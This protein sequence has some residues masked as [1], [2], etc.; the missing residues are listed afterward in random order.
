MVGTLLVL[1]VFLIKQASY[2][3]SRETKL[4]LLCMQLFSASQHTAATHWQTTA[5]IASLT[6][7][8]CSVYITVSHM[9]S[10]FLQTP[11]TFTMHRVSLCVACTTIPQQWWRLVWHL[12][13]LQKAVW[14]WLSVGLQTNKRSWFCWVVS[15]SQDNYLL[16]NADFDH[17]TNNEDSKTA[18]YMIWFFFFFPTST[19]STIFGLVVIPMFSGLWDIVMSQEWL[20]NTALVVGVR[21]WMQHDTTPNL[22]R[23]LGVVNKSP[24][25]P[26]SNNIAHTDS[27]CGLWCIGYKYGLGQPVITVAPATWGRRSTACPPSRSPTGHNKIPSLCERR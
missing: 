9:L 6:W 1:H 21:G 5:K 3:I 24:S 27:R 2:D 17:N 19:L 16:N 12:K 13:L 22:T 15:S 20:E 23:G 25:N 11:F 14:P 4:L 8:G 7:P 18:H 26:G 10:E